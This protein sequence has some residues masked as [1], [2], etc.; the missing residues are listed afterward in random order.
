MS[1]AEPGKVI[2]SDV[3]KRILEGQPQ[4]IF[5]SLGAANL[6]GFEDSNE[7]FDLTTIILP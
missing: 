5:K 6:K 7:I 4:F 3:V 1:K 2:T